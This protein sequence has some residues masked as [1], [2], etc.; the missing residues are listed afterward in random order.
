[1]PNLYDF[2]VAFLSAF[3][4]MHEV[5]IIHH[6]TLS[7]RDISYRCWITYICYHCSNFRFFFGRANVFCS[8]VWGFQSWTNIVGNCII[9]THVEVEA[10]LPSI[11]R[12]LP[13]LE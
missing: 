9:P 13:G 6:G 11:I 7:L 3:Q 10:S 1:M 4:V 12:C 8:G 5:D 2:I